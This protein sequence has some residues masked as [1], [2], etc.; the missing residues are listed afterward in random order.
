MKETTTLILGGGFGG[1]ATANALRQLAPKEHRIVLV[2]SSPAFTLGAAKTWVMLGQR[3]PEEVM[4]PRAAGLKKRGIEY[5]Q[6]TVHKIDAS[7]QEV[8][9]SRGLLRG[10]YL[11]IALGADLEMGLVPGLA[12]A[13]QTFYTLAGAAKLRDT[14]KA[15]PGG[16]I[17]LLIPRAPFKCPPAPYEAAF[18]LDYQF[19]IQRR[20]DKIRLSLYTLEAAPMATAGPEMGQF[21]RAA[22]AERQIAFHPQKRVQSV[23]SAERRI[24]FEDG[25]EAKYDLLIAV[26]PHQAPKAV[27]ES[28]LTNAAG[29]I[30]TEAQTGKVVAFADSHRVYAIGDITAVPLPGRFKPDAPLV[31]PKAGVFAEKQGRVVA[32][33]IAARLR[34]EEP[35]AAYDGTGYCYIEMGD[36]H[37]VR[38]D[39]EFFALPHPQMSRR[40]PDL[41]QYEEKL[42]WA[43]DW[44]K[45]NLG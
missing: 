7:K 31:L 37:A 11:V 36:H 45:A 18:L 16:E 6:A 32:A 44:V 4:H 2:D 10:D 23:V 9:T 40:V 30:P 38:G 21:I 43:R 35:I 33:Q 3:R 28:G 42:A 34:G 13:A 39:G 25:S 27:R 41:M 8:E 22:L 17:V 12:E 14:L 15:F 29:W 1:L 19:K 5:T 26:P 24:Q 20:R